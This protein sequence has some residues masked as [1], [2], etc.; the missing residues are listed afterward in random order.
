M[1]NGIDTFVTIGTMCQ[2]VYVVVAVAIFMGDGKSGN[3]LCCQTTHYKQARTCRGCYTPFLELSTPRENMNCQWVLQAEQRDL[4][5]GCQEPGKEN[6]EKL[7]ASL[8]R[9]STIRCDSLMFDLNYGSHPWGQ[10]FA[11]TVDLM[12]AFEVGFVVHVIKAFCCWD[13]IPS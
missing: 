6:D 2:R 12:H 5:K 7:R 9:V 11:C 10:F 3:T 4:T 13:I 1:K 8:K